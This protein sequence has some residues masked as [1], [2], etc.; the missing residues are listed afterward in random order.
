MTA[1]A[2]EGVYPPQEDSLLLIDALESSG[3]VHGRRVVD[4]CTGSGVVAIAAARLGAQTV[5]A[6]DICPH[7]VRCATAN[8]LAAGVSVGVRL[9]SWSQALD[10]APYDLVVCNPPYVPIGS[11]VDAAT[12]APWAGPDT[13][14]NGGADG[15][16]ILDPL[17]DTAPA[18]LGDGGTLLL[19]QSEF[20]DVEQSLVRLGKAGLTAEVCAS[21]WIPW[22]PVVSSQAGWLKQ[23]GRLRHDRRDERLVVIRADK[24]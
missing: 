24:S 13:A 4:L 8:V 3:A 10:D 1:V 23:T 20:A 17:C 21:Q 16:A 18:L 11:A 7:A 2:G 5:T 22:G 14:W 15:R 9:G 19:V 12:V 6:L